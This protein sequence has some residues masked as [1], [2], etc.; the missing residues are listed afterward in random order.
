MRNKA[1]QGAEFI[2]NF[3][4]TGSMALVPKGQLNGKLGI[5]TGADLVSKDITFLRTHLER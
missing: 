5:E 2:T 1:W 3:P 4:F